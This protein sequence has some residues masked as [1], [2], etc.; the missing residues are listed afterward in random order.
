MEWTQGRF[1]FSID[2]EV[3]STRTADALPGGARWPF[4]RR[5]FHLLLTLSVGGPWAG[6]PNASTQ[7]PARFLVD[8][9]RVMRP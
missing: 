7:W 2:G 9:I 8:W 3:Y 6:A 1:E 4:D 5:Y